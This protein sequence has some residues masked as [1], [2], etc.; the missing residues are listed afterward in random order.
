MLVVGAL[1]WVRKWSADVGGPKAGERERA[2]ASVMGA[3][4]LGREGLIGAVRV[5][6]FGTDGDLVAGEFLAGGCFEVGRLRGSEEQKP[7]ADGL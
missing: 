3:E 1:Y 5:V 4:G 2:R 7:A 6:G